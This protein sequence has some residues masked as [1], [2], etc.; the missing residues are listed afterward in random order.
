MQIKICAEKCKYINYENVGEAV[1]RV[2]GQKEPLV[3]EL[4]FCSEEEIKDLNLRERNVNSVTDVLS[5]PS[6][7]NIRGKVI[8]KKDFPFDYDESEG[9]VFIGSIAI[10]VKRAEEQ[11]VLYEHS[12]EREFTFLTVHA[13]LHLMGYDHMTEEDRLEMRALEDEIMRILDVGEV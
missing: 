3:A 5:F 9:G 6:L 11:A 1:W 7:D 4:I 10:C 2:L 13:L 12:R 8:Y